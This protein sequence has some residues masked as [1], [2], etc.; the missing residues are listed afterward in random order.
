MDRMLSRNATLDYNS[1]PYIFD[2]I[3]HKAL[4]I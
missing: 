3:N 2:E 4:N 1:S